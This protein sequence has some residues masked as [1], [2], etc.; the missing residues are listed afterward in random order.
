MKK[1]Y[2][3]RSVYY[4]AFYEIV[5]PNGTHLDHFPTFDSAVICIVSSIVEGSTGVK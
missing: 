3:G 5:F 2:I 4:P 1:A